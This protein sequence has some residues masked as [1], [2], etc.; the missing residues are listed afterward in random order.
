MKCYS[1]YKHQ[2]KAG[3]YLDALSL[4]K[5][6]ISASLE[7][8]SFF[9][10]D[11]DTMEPSLRID[12]F[13]RLG[14]P[15]FIYPHSGYPFTVRWDG[16]YNWNKNIT[17]VFAHS[18][19]GVEVPQMYGFDKPIHEVGWSYCSIEKF[20]PQ[21]LKKVLF[22]PIHPNFNGWLSDEDKKINSSTMAI[23]LKLSQQFGFKLTVKY[24]GRLEDGGLERAEGVRYSRSHPNLVLALKEIQQANLVVSH[25]TLACLAIAQGKPTLMMATDVAPRLGHSPDLYTHATHFEDYKHLIMYPLDILNPTG[26]YADM[27]LG[28]LSSDEAMRDWKARMIGKPFDRKKFVDIVERYL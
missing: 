2:D 20:Q 6:Y 16:M 5:W 11:R 7:S 27:L 21:P 28:A 23:L 14:K 22:A 17:A 18:P 15:S 13:A 26:S 1:I 8:S 25:E 3:P 19:A 9:L 24:T 10:T 4:R 12:E